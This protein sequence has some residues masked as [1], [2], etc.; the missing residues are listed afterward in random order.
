MVL[1]IITHTTMLIDLNPLEQQLC[2]NFAMRRVEF[3][4]QGHMLDKNK[5]I[6]VLPNWYIYAQGM[7]GELAAC[8]YFGIYPEL[9]PSPKNQTPF[10]FISKTG[11]KVDVKTTDREDG[12]LICPSLK[13]SSEADIFVLVIGSLPTYRMAGWIE[14]EKFLIP[15]NLIDLGHGEVFGL[16]QKDL[17]QF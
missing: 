16:S 3:L 2:I 5:K 17:N 11:K 13:H 6:G 15:E 14:R 8:K 7:G 4:D 9:D 10:D 12:R 1:F